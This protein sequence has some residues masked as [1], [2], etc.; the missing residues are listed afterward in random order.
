MFKKIAIQINL[1]DKP[2]EQSHK[3]HKTA[4]PLMGGAAMCTTWCITLLIGI[5]APSVLPIAQL[6]QTIM[7]NLTGIVDVTPKLII[8]IIGGILISLL[9]FI[10]DKYNMNAKTKFF[11]Q[12]F[13]VALVVIFTDIKITLFIQTNIIHMLLSILWIVV[14]INAINFFDNMDGLAVGIASIAFFFFTTAALIFNHYFVASLG[15]VGLGTTLGFWFYNHSPA[16]IFMGDSGSHFLGYILGITSAYTTYYQQGITHSYLSV[17]IPIFIMALPLFDLLSVVIIRLKIK[18]PI[19]IGDNNHISHRFCKM[20]MSRKTSVFCVHLLAV[21]IGLSVLPLLWGDEK[22]TIVCFIQAC[23]ILIL[24]S[25]V[26][27]T[28]RKK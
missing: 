8:I 28:A 1:I 13:I 17:L 2:S 12:F 19:Y 4:I 14:I 15:A 5:L 24:I 18:K 23:I 26:Q 7:D 27:F 25:I 6:P 22:T 16:S 3:K 10:D 9:G 20:G 11:G 21:I